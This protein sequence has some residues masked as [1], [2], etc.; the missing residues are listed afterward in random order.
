MRT[1]NKLNYLNETKELIKEALIEKGVEV[2]DT[3]TFR[4]YANKVK[5]IST[6]E[7]LSVEL[8]EQDM[9]IEELED[10]AHSLPDAGGVKPEGTMLIKQNGIYDVAD[11]A[12][13]DVQVETQLAP[14]PDPPVFGIGNFKE[15]GTYLASDYNIDGWSSLIIDVPSSGG[16]E[17]D[18]NE[19]MYEMQKID[20][21]LKQA[22]AI[23]FSEIPASD[24]YL[25]QQSIVNN[26]IEK[27]MGVPFNA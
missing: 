21:L 7:D 17:R 25:E 2:S 5:S 15:N 18:P 11:I 4:S 8:A 3:D 24:E 23:S 6:A 12:E 20:F 10:I 9:A 22:G 13:V 1:S 19:T 26:L 27:I 14:T 16:G